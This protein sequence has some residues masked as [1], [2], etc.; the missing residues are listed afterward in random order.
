[1]RELAAPMLTLF[2]FALALVLVAMMMPLLMLSKMVSADAA[3]RGDY[4][5]STC[6]SSRV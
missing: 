3:A 6:I 4:S 5:A 2:A 1:M